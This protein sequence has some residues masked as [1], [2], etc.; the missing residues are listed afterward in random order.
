MLFQIINQCEIKQAGYVG[1]LHNTNLSPKHQQQREHLPGH[2]EDT[3]V[4]CSHNIQGLG[5]FFCAFFLTANF[6]GLWSL[7]Y[8]IWIRVS[9]K[10]LLLIINRE[11]ETCFN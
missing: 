5:V 4:A 1:C 2:P 8:Q 11:V 9:L 10:E 7:T 3:V 6:C